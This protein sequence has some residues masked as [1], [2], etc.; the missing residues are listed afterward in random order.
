METTLKMPEPAEVGE[1][2]ACLYG[3]EPKCSSASDTFLDDLHAIAGY[4]QDDSK[5]NWV[6]GCDLEFA[7]RFGAALT[8][9]PASQAEESIK[10]GQLLE[11][12]RENIAEIMNILVNLLPTSSKSRLT[13]QR[14]EVGVD[15]A[16]L[17][18][19][20]NNEAM[21]CYQLDLARYG[22]GRLVIAAAE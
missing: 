21:Q 1:F 3:K 19:L 16:A 17:Q 18:S 10:S 11:S 9:M 2:A 22:E 7:A 14:F 12:I 4:G 13:M 20:I 5:I 6:V 15:G 8:M